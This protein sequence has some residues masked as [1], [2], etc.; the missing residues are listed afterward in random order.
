[1]PGI[2][3]DMSFASLSNPQKKN[4]RPAAPCLLRPSYPSR[5]HT[6]RCA[7]CR[8]RARRGCM[9]PGLGSLAGT[10]R[11]SAHRTAPRTPLDT[12]SSPPRPQAHQVQDEHLWWRHHPGDRHLESTK[13]QTS[14]NHWGC[15]PCFP[16]HSW[17][18][19][20]TDRWVQLVRWIKMQNPPGR[21]REM[22]KDA[23]EL[24]ERACGVGKLR[25]TI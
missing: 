19:W 17:T 13:G 8:R 2:E 9:A 14:C 3:K 22:R 4:H 21:L 12:S 23:L 11:C 25:M 18:V 20:G 16:T 15:H 7:R 24:T 1:M 10:Q 5:D 6:S